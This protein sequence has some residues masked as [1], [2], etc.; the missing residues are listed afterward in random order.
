MKR[1]TLG[2][3]VAL[4]LLAGFVGAQEKITLSTPV[5]QQAGVSEFRVEGLYLKRAHPDAP[6]EIRAILREVSG[7][8]FVE[9]GRVLVCR[10]DGAEADALIVALNKANL[11]TTSLEKRVLQRCQADGKLGAGTITGS[12]Q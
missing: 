11:S 2:L 8:A 5:Y 6:A 7:T 3:V 1:Y 4:G 10:Y 12:V 9:H